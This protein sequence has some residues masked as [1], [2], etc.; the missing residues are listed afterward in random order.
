LLLTVSNAFVTQLLLNNWVLPFINGDLAFWLPRR[1]VPRRGPPPTPPSAPSS[2]SSSTL[3]DS[4]PEVASGSRPG[5]QTVYSRRRANTTQLREK[6]RLHREVCAAAVRPPSATNP[7]PD[8]RS[9]NPSPGS[10]QSP[11]G[12]SR[13]TP[14]GHS[15]PVVALP[16]S[17]PSTSSAPSEFPPLPP[18]S[19]L[20]LVSARVACELD[21]ALNPFE[22]PEDMEEED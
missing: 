10:S 3:P 21:L 22:S 4:S 5:W 20:D 13:P 18:P 1:A 17:Q 15:C 11:A 6:K 19:R 8:S 9:T 7:P 16:G 2:G 12:P 14:L